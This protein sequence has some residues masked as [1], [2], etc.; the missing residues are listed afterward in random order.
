VVLPSPRRHAQ[1]R[2]EPAQEVPGHLQRQLS[3]RRL[4]GPLGRLA[5]DLP[6]V[7]RPRR[8]G[9]PRRQP[10]HQ[11]GRLLGVA[12][13]GDPRHRSRRD[14]PGGGLHPPR[15]D[16]RAGQG[17]LQPVLHVLHLE[18]LEVGARAVPDGARP[19][20]GRLLPAEL[21][22]QHAGHPAR[23]PAA[24]RAPR[25]RGAADPGEHA[26]PQLRDLQ[27]LRA[28]RERAGPRGQ[29]G[30][31]ELREV[32]GQAARARRAA[33]ADGP[34]A[35]PSA[36]R[37]PGAA[38]AARAALPRHPQRLAD[39]LRQGL[40]GR[41]RDQRREHRSAQRAGGPRDRAGRPRPRAGVRRPRR[42]RRQRLRL[43]GN[44]VRLGGGGD[45]SRQAHVLEVIR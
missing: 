36:P 13:Q 22:R 8:E 31:P 2:G 12:D 19:R 20:D 29:R 7:G 30:V 11:A 35:Q 37:P 32:R 34:G 24:R 25:V 38:A 5:G 45:S 43:A 27:R 28:L 9:L 21:L 14:L 44:Y 41:R 1:V 6:A 3:V 42:A 39:R 23:L 16:A 40:G 26:E 18:E 17:G 4:E 33:A 10:A 15:D